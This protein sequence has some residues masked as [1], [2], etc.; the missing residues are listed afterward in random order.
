[1]RNR[2]GKLFLLVLTTVVFAACGGR[3]ESTVGEGRITVAALESAY[4]SA[5]WKEVTQAFSAKTGIEVELVIDRNIEDV[6]A[7]GMQA[8]DFPDVVHLAT[9]RERALTETMIKEG[10][11]EPLADMLEMV[12]PGEN[13]RVRDKIAGGFL[14]SSLTNPYSDR[15]TY[16]APMFYSPCGLFYNANLLEQKGW[17][18]PST[19]DEMWE[20]GDKARAEGIAL[21]AYPTAGYFDAFFYALLY[22]VG[23]TDFFDRATTFTEGIWETEE[24]RIVFDIIETL[25]S[26][27][28]RSVPSN[29]NSAN[30][31][32]N[33][34]LVL[35]N[36]AIFMP[37]GTWVTGEMRDAPRADGFEWGLTGLPA[38]E[39][40]GDS[41]SYTWFEQAWIPAGARNKDAAKTFLAYLYSDEAAAIFARSSAYQPIVGLGDML[42]GE[43][44]LFYSIYDGGT[45]AALGA[46][47]TTVPVEGVTVYDTFFA[48]VDSLVNGSRT[49]EMWVNQIKRNSDLLRAAL[50]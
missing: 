41:Y 27:T 14:E 12:I 37:N 46:F 31:T 32:R 30:F 28:E 47:A 39:A 29:A 19:W 34:Q 50:K 42:E 2:T 25:A 17:D 40:G 36:K 13:V 43:N 16:L 3:G 4:G 5:L 11:L 15:K 20:L 48:P 45:K 22:V 6:I 8:G 1:M 23:G 49:R 18:L 10:A 26:Y 9:G 21:F 44:S 35:D 7:P 33:Q 24:A 38:L